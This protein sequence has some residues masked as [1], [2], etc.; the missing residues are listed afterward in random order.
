M[1]AITNRTISLPASESRAITVFG[2]EFDP[3]SQVLITF[4]AGPGGQPQNFQT[5]TDAFGTFSTT[6]N[7]VEPGEGVHLIR[8]DDFR[9]R[10][11]D[12]TYRIPCFMPS[13]ALD[14]AIGPPGFVT[15]AVGT[16]F[17]ANSDIVLLN[18]EQPG[19]ASPLPKTVRTNADGAFEY[20]ILILYHDILGPRLLQAI[21]ANPQGD[22]AGAAIEA[23]APFLVTP[24]R[25]QPPDLVLRR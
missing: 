13:V 14:P 10:E 8:A 9:E 5:T 20:P 22:Q 18:W 17:P 25:S 23:D 19:L 7:V 16:G 24:G 12:T 11:A 15:T 1:K 21:V 2:Q 3:F 4:D 6:I